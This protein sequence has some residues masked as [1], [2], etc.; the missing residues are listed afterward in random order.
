MK[1]DKGSLGESFQT[2]GTEH[3]WEG[4]D[5]EV[6]SDPLIDDGSGKKVILRFFHYGLN[7]DMLKYQKPTDQDIFNS[8]AQQI[9]VTLWADGLVPYERVTPQVI[10]SKKSKSNYAVM[11]ACEAKAGVAV[12][13]SAQT[14]QDL[15]K[16]NG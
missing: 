15:I 12:I 5:I 14:L 9:K 2:V 6:Q 3:K 16:N 10:W 7:P 4:Q 13:E 11:V 8:H 1:D